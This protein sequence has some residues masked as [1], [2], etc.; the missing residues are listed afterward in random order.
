VNNYPSIPAEKGT[1]TNN[2][3]EFALQKGINIPLLAR[4]LNIADL[5]CRDLCNG[6][7]EPSFKTERK[8][9]KVLGKPVTEIYP[10]CY[11][12]L[13]IIEELI[14]KDNE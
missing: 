13:D 11:D 2:I 4:I 7:R 6:K 3:K 1:Y 12:N 14:P 8:L 10:N 9:E 5:T